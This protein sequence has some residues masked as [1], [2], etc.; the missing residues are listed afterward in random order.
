[1]RRRLLLAASLAAAAC[2]GGELDRRRSGTVVDD[3]TSAGVAGVRVACLVGGAVEGT[4]WLTGAD[5]RFT[6]FYDREC[7]EISAEDADGAVNGRYASRTVAFPS[8]DGD[9]EVR[10]TRLP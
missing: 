9:I 10:L 1:M 2:S 3:A 6:V 8:S 4:R 5:G 7:E